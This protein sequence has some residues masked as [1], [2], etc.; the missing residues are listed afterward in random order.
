MMA[1]GRHVLS[2]IQSPF[3]GFIEDKTT[4]G[5]FMRDFVSKIRAA[6]KSASSKE[7]VRYWIN[8]KRVEKVKEAL[9]S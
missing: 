4:D 7:Q 3:A 9:C 6:A 2:N 1:A 5:A 8:P